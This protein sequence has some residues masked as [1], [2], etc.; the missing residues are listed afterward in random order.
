MSIVVEIYRHSNHVATLRSDGSRNGAIQSAHMQMAE[1][2]FKAN[3]YRLEV[4]DSGWCRKCG[5]DAWE[6]QYCI[7]PGVN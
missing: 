3:E 1:E 6:N 2:G 7:C 5:G 4:F